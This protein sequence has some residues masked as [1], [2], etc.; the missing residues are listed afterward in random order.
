TPSV[1][2]VYALRGNAAQAPL[3]TPFG[4]ADE[5][6]HAEPNVGSGVIVRSDG[7]ILTNHHV[8]D[9]ADE[10]KVVLWDRREY[11]ATIQA[12]DPHTDLTLLKVEAQGL[13]TVMSGDSHGR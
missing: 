7:M 6:S 8:V 5:G 9:A 10:V 13:H 1:V 4:A 3:F 12:S 11:R 2:T